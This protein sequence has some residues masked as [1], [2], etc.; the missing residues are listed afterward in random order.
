MILLANPIVSFWSSA[1]IKE[2]TNLENIITTDLSPFKGI[3]R[4]KI[5]IVERKTNPSIT[6]AKDLSR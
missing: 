2:Y 6:Y 3:Q 4:H 5:N 1:S